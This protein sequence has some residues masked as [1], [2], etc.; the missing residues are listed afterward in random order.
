MMEL[1]RPETT[2]A[3]TKNQLAEE[4]FAARARNHTRLML[5]GKKA[6]YKVSY[7]AVFLKKNFCSIRMSAFLSFFCSFFSCSK[8]AIDGP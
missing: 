8:R 1:R 2:P 5:E 3:T 4:L 7:R 6:Y